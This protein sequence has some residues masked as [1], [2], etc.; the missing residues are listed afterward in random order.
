MGDFEGWYRIEHPR[1]LAAAFVAAGDLDVAREVT[2]EAF[3]RAYER[4]DDVGRMANPSGW[5]YVVALNLVR[6]RWRWRRRENGDLTRTREVAPPLEISEMRVDVLCAVQSL[7]RRARI[8]VA[9]RYFAGLS[10]AEVAEAMGV[11]PGTASAT[12]SVARRRLAL[13][14]ADY[15]SEETRHD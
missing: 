7:S 10:E 1:V 2:A 5:T 11:A 4:W 3:S 14:L 12:L 9:L 8:A 6:R 15:A 13:A